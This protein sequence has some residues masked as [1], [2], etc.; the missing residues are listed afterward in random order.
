MCF[1]KRMLSAVH[2]YSKDEPSRNEPN[3]RQSPGGEV[4]MRRWT[5]KERNAYTGD[6]ETTDENAPIERQRP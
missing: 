6:K 1:H 2:V 4:E 5:R 3:L